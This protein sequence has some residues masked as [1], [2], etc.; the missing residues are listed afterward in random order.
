M[1]VC[2]CVCVCTFAGDE[3]GLHSLSVCS[4]RICVPGCKCLGTGGGGGGEELK[5]WP[6]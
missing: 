5:E 6:L 3:R 4:W 2:V 1:C